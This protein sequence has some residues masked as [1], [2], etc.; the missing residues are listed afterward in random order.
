MF[1]VIM[2][3][4]L[5]FFHSIYYF[6]RYLFNYYRITPHRAGISEGIELSSFK[7]ILK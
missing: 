6:K 5:C 7:Q 2:I 1:L 4:I 3:T